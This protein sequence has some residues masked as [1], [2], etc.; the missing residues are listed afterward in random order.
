MNENFRGQQVKK[1][2][3]DSNVFPAPW[4]AFILS[5]SRFKVMFTGLVC[6]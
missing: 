6:Y 1:K 4:T 3:T 5:Q 2:T